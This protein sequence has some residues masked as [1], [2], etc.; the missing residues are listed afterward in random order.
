METTAME[1]TASTA[2]TAASLGWRTHCEKHR[3]SHRRDRNL[4]GAF[5]LSLVRFF[6]FS[7]TSLLTPRPNKKFTPRQVNLH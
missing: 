6:V 1:T 4:P 5:S 2:A 3:R 7:Y